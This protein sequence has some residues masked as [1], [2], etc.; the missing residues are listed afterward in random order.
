MQKNVSEKNNNNKKDQHPL[1]IKKPLNNVG[2]KQ[3]MS[4]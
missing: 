3:H 2:L 4:I 1:R